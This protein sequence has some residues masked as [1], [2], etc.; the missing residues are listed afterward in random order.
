[1]NTASSLA[2][3]RLWFPLRFGVPARGPVSRKHEYNNPA[4]PAAATRRTR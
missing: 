3:S 4:M 1:L 2:H